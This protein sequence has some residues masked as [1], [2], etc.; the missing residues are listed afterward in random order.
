MNEE[1]LEQLR[2]QYPN[3]TEVQ[4]NRLVA[5]QEGTPTPVPAGMEQTVSNEG[6]YDPWRPAGTSPASLPQNQILEPQPTSLEDA[7][8]RVIAEAKAS[9]EAGILD[10]GK[11]GLGI[12]IGVTA[13]TKDAV[14]LWNENSAI[15]GADEILGL[16][17]SEPDD[18]EFE[19]KTVKEWKELVEGKKKD[20]VQQ[21]LSEYK[22]A[23]NTM[24]KW[25]KW[26]G[27]EDAVSKTWSTINSPDDF[28]KF[29]AETI[30]Q[31]A[32]MAGGAMLTGGMGTFAL[33]TGMVQMDQI[34]T[35]LDED[36]N[37]TPEIILEKALA[38]PKWAAGM[39]IAAGALDIFSL[40]ILSKSMGLNRVANKFISKGAKEFFE[41]G[42]AQ[43]LKK[44]GRSGRV[45]K[46]VGTAGLAE[47]G[48]EPIQGHLENIGV[49]RGIGKER[50]WLE[51]DR[52]QFLT[53]FLAGFTGG[54]FFAGGGAF[55]SSNLDT[56][57]PAVKKIKEIGD[58][59]ITDLDEF[60]ETNISDE[61]KQV[62]DA[63]E[64]SLQEELGNYDERLADVEKAVRIDEVDK[65]AKKLGAKDK[66]VYKEQK[67][68]TKKIDAGLDRLIKALNLDESKEAQEILAEETKPDERA[69]Q[70]KQESMLD[71]VKQ[72][73]EQ[74]EIKTSK[75]PKAK[76]DV[77]TPAKGD[78]ST[79]GLKTTKKEKNENL[80]DKPKAKTTAKEKSA[81]QR[82]AVQS[83]AKSQKKDIVKPKTKK[84]EQITKQDQEKVS[85]E[86]ASRGSKDKVS[87]TVDKLRTKDE[88]KEI[89]DK[90]KAERAK[91]AK[92][93]PGMV[94]EET[95]KRKAKKK[96][97]KETAYW[98][99]TYKRK[100]SELTPKML[101]KIA[102]D[103][104]WAGHKHRK[105]AVN[106]LA[107][108]AK[109][110]KE[111]DAF[112][113]KLEAK[114]KETRAPALE[115]TVKALKKTGLKE[116]G[117]VKQKDLTM[118]FPTKEEA[119]AD[120]AI[121]KYV[122]AKKKA[123]KEAGGN[124][125]F[126]TAAQ[127]REFIRQEALDVIEKE[128]DP[129]SVNL[130]E[131]KDEQEKKKAAGRIFAEETQKAL[132]KSGETIEVNLGREGAGR[133]F[134]TADREGRAKYHTGRTKSSTG[135]RTF[136]RSTEGTW[137]EKETGRTPSIPNLEEMYI[138][139]TKG[140]TIDKVTKI[141]DTVTTVDNIEL[142]VENVII[143]GTPTPVSIKDYMQQ[144]AKEL[145]KASSIFKDGVDNST[146]KAV[147]DF[148]AILSEYAE[149]VSQMLN[150]YAKKGGLER[151][152]VYVVEDMVDPRKPNN[153]LAGAMGTDANNNPV[154]LLRKIP[155]MLEDWKDNKRGFSSPS[156]IGVMGFTE[157]N[158]KMA[159]F[160]HQWVATHEL[161]H[162][163]DNLIKRGLSIG[164]KPYP[165]VGGKAYQKYKDNNK[166]H[167]SKA[168]AALAVLKSD[169]SKGNTYNKRLYNAVKDYITFLYPKMKNPMKV[170]VKDSDEQVLGITKAEEFTAELINPFFGSILKSIKYDNNSRLSDTN[171]IFYKMM[172]QLNE[173]VGAILGRKP[174][175][176]NINGTLLAA[177]YNNINDFYNQTI[178]EGKIMRKINASGGN[179]NFISTAPTKDKAEKRLDKLVDSLD[180]TL[181]SKTGVHPKVA[182][183]VRD[184][185]T[186]LTANNDKQDIA[187][188]T[189]LEREATE[190]LAK[191]ETVDNAMGIFH[192]KL[193]S[194]LQLSEAEQ[195]ALIKEVNDIVKDGKSMRAE[196][197][198]AQK[199][200]EGKLVDTLTNEL[201]RGKFKVLNPDT[202][203]NGGD[204]IVTTAGKG[205]TT[206]K[207]KIVGNKKL[208]IEG[209]L[210]SK[211]LSLY[212]EGNKKLRTIIDEKLTEEE[213]ASLEGL[214]IISQGSLSPKDFNLSP[215]A[216]WINKTMGTILFDRIRTLDSM[217]E[218]MTDPSKNPLYEG[219]LSIFTNM[220]RKSGYAYAEATKQKGIEMATL[221]QDIFDKS[222]TKIDNEMQEVQTITVT[223]TSKLGTT[224]EDVKYKLTNG[225]LVSLFMQLQDE[226]LHPRFQLTGYNVKELR[227]IVSESLSPEMKK[228][229]NALLGMYANY[230]NPI[231]EIYRKVTGNDLTKINKYSPIKQDA[232]TASEIKNIL[233]STFDYTNDDLMKVFNS[234]MDSRAGYIPK[235]LDSSLEDAQTVMTN[236]IGQ[237]E[238][239]MA[240][241]E[242]NA[243]FQKIFGTNSLV[244]SLIEKRMG[245]HYI[246]IIDS[247]VNTQVSGRILNRG[248]FASQVI[249]WIRNRSIIPALAA[250]LTLLPKQVGSFIAFTAS[251]PFG[252]YMRYALDPT[253]W[254]RGIK[255]VHNSKYVRMRWSRGFERELRE[256]QTKLNEFGTIRPTQ[257]SAK[258]WGDWVRQ[259][260]MFPVRVGDIGAIY[261]GGWPA[262]LHLLDKT[263]KDNPKWTEEKIRAKA[264]F[265]FGK[266]S[267]LAQQSTQNM[268]LSFIQSTPYGRLFTMYQSSPILYM[269]QVMDSSR[270]VFT[271]KTSGKLRRSA[272]YKVMMYQF[273]LPML[274]H[275]ISSKGELPEDEDGEIDLGA[276]TTQVGVG[277]F[278]GLP[279]AGAMLQYG[280]NKQ[281]GKNFPY[282][283]SPATRSVET[284]FDFLGEI[285]DEIL[286]GD[287]ITSADYEYWTQDE[288]VL[289]DYAEVMSFI[290]KMPINQLE[291][292][293]R[294]QQQYEDGRISPR[295]R[296]WQM[297][298]YSPY[299]VPSL[300]KEMEKDRARIKKYGK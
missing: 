26:G 145:R 181:K 130:K 148:T 192:S 122:Q 234:H 124:W 215:I 257:S 109:K 243:T 97:P 29:A 19:G 180:K 199:K 103:P 36:P 255:E 112:V 213:Q 172:S 222:F 66:A 141:E 232:A 49:D 27:S 115:S 47:G 87:G 224:S 45:L 220:L 209:K 153:K 75:T 44:A 10:Y 289:K 74:G 152:Q 134:F 244:R 51:I 60:K 211:V 88:I 110:Q 28:F 107:K 93:A 174:D 94:E 175:L 119:A 15:H 266:I 194:L 108:Q 34:K 64:E 159:A 58:K 156:V 140:K 120:K 48:T 46:A 221:K 202:V 11:R 90:V 50:G 237:M 166:K 207:Y 190:A 70:K 135:G 219:P 162:A 279:V 248:V 231:N 263:K 24:S 61:V 160:H 149:A 259:K 18:K 146:L 230:H 242:S 188:P 254:A 23:A 53:E 65:A 296:F 191:D 121:E 249:D 84:D 179:T 6:A 286:E 95:E 32:P 12:G 163:M 178:V 105:A 282:R 227:T 111:H 267:D 106:K 33:E 223:R 233:T 277:P 114:T 265:E 68:I 59:I 2:Q 118:E 236:Y 42:A 31:M 136:Y 73:K 272:I 98:K 171:N 69:A 43:T 161:V 7:T 150:D 71:F 280:I 246:G 21:G 17:D 270:R 187:D 189:K 200:I 239:F 129:K 100:I 258:K 52:E 57:D 4:L 151:F 92:L 147:D 131:K 206:I 104:E 184:I 269:N 40:G 128:N 133:G 250:N 264:D 300:E 256:F 25:V 177:A 62:M 183:L 173:L 125:D 291:K 16:L 99:N 299:S 154:V 85:R 56:N 204:L 9:K 241:A 196:E 212:A 176:E 298:G 208:K 83:K 218:K 240:F 205:G 201:T 216:S 41:K 245:K 167:F 203:Y 217:M 8:A 78:R 235:E 275:L 80:Q 102:T 238:R 169:L 142:D 294:A 198:K 5:K 292:R 101:T 168:Q 137:I 37:L 274:F 14:D 247:I 55:I 35:L 210:V 228:Y 67:G 195:V 63:T 1:L 252:S 278:T 123:V 77:T 144:V 229:G 138:L 89:G 113:A 225:Q 261:V 91:G 72:D 214:D 132:D 3:L 38:D 170:W 288:G 39:G 79:E 193:S 293:W 30:G 158:A 157:R 290:T 276:I 186:S 295:N 96:N 281:K 283:W 126:N 139:L 165:Y 182:K 164:G 297:V 127:E 54:G 285:K 271:P 117:R 262:Y 287:G 81:V 284:T 76:D 197:M 226:S 155:E 22:Q 86:P 253:Q 251:V 273:I 260:A 268:D 82:K 143:K 116:L 20:A 185:K 13:S